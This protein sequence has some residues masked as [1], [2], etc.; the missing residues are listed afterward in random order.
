MF[1]EYC[2]SRRRFCAFVLYQEAMGQ[3]DQ[4]LTDSMSDRLVFV[5]VKRIELVVNLWNECCIILLLNS[6]RFPRR[7]T[8]EAKLFELNC[9]I[10]S[11]FLQ[12]QMCDTCGLLPVQ[13]L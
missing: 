13:H 5:S 2:E 3:W 1:Y 12:I 4:I 6:R 7:G 8:R 9:F 10:Y 11:V